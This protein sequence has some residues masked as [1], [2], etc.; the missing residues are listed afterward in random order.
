[1]EN[2]SKIIRIDPDVIKGEPFWWGHPLASVWFHAFYKG[3]PALKKMPE[4]S[5]F[6]T[7]LFKILH[8]LSN[9]YFLKNNITAQQD[10]RPPA[11]VHFWKTTLL[12]VNVLMNCVFAKWNTRFSYDFQTIFSRWLLSFTSSSI[13]PENILDSNPFLSMVLL[14]SPSP[15]QSRAFLDKH[16]TGLNMNR[17]S[18]M[19]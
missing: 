1:M 14:L 4:I 15:P 3:C 10:V 17:W 8:L 19:K 16:P 5:L 18:R 11:E 13:I 6:K 2:V 9:V 12:K 7:N